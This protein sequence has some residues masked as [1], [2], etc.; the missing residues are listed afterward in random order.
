MTLLKRGDSGEQ[1]AKLQERL[2]LTA[3]GIFGN[4]TQRAVVNFQTEHDLFPDGI[5][6]DMTWTALFLNGANTFTVVTIVRDGSEVDGTRGAL[7]INGEE[8]CKTLELADYDNLPQ[9]SCI[10]KG[11]YRCTMNYSP[12]FKRDL[13]MV[14]DVPN[15]TGIRI[16]P[17]NFAGDTRQGLV[18]DLLGCIALGTHYVTV[19]GQTMILN[20]KITLDKFCAILENKD[21]TLEII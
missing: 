10:P 1:V 9:Y 14:L 18:S 16:H 8:F 15:R 17:A 21:F 5:V 13:Y 3:D 7:S 20:S 4:D 2:G 12:K 19:D 11:T 6:G